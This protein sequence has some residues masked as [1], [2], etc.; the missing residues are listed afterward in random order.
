MELTCGALVTL[1]GLQLGGVEVLD[2]LDV[3][4]VLADAATFEQIAGLLRNILADDA[5]GFFLEK[6]DHC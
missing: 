3:E 4:R 5:A 6:S 1:P 2:A